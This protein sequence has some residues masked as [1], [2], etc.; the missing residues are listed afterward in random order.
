QEA[1]NRAWCEAQGNVDIAWSIT[2]PGYS[3]SRHRK[4]ERPGYAEAMAKIAGADPVDILVAWE[5]SRYQ[6]DLEVHVELR[7]LC[8][9]G[10][11][12]VKLAYKGRVMD[13]ANPGDRFSAG[14]DALIAERESEE[15]RE[16][17]LRSV[18]ANVAAGKPHGRLA[19]GYRSVHDTATG[20]VVD[21]VPD[22]A[23]APVV[24]EIVRRVGA[25]DAGYAIA[26][27]LNARGVPSP[28]AYRSARLGRTVDEP[29]PWTLE[30]VHRVARNPAYAGLRTHKGTVVGEGTWSP[31][32]SLAEH[33][34]AVARLSAPGRDS[35]RNPGEAGA[36]HLLS[37]IALCGVCGSPCR[38]L[39]NRGSPS[40]VCWGGPAKRG[41]SCV[42][43]VQLPVDIL[44]AETIIEWAERPDIA[45]RLAE[46][47]D[48]EGAAAAAAEVVDLERQLAELADAVIGKR[49]TPALAGRI[50]A[51]LLP[52][53]EAARERSIPR[54]VPV[55][56]RNL[57]GPHARRRWELEIDVAERRRIV[58]AL[59]EV[60]ILKSPRRGSRVFDP[61]LVD[62]RWLDPF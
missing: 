3:A 45:K 44:V 62:V 53:L 10:G 22:E 54:S 11:R 23:V 28:H 38:M 41:T 13:F 26:G 42:A 25:G 1:E 43:R 59:V 20:R 14:L 50:E 18:R 6:R 58:R 27:D 40:Y 17:I 7:K 32:V 49:M 56:V 61:D 12:N 48:D 34:R 24:A 30:Q 29:Y 47:H 31:I 36:K 37:G 2:D 4:R 19:Y 46:R 52:A 8:T 16:R 35:R 51:G 60:T 5:A 39:P 15:T 33:S 9:G 21:R 57:V 55:E